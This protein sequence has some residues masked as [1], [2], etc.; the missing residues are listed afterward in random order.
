VFDNEK[1][2]AFNALK[3]S[4]WKMSNYKKDVNCVSFV[5]PFRIMF[6]PIY[7]IVFYCFSNHKFLVMS[8]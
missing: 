5:Y 1:D 8:Y 7:L 3:A 2:D 4:I 6:K